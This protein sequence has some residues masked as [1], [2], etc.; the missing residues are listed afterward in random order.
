MKTDK[1]IAYNP[2]ACEYA[3]F[4]TF[5]EAREWLIDNQDFSGGMLVEYCEGLAFIAKITH[6][7]IVYVTDKKENYPCLKDPDAPAHCSSCE[8]KDCEETKKRQF[9]EVNSIVEVELKEVD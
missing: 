1:Y 5:D 4:K 8:E 2:N 7:T 6:R 3:A 9:E